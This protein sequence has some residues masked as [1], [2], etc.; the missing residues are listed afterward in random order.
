MSNLTRTQRLEM[1]PDQFMELKSK[2]TGL[3]TSLDALTLSNSR[4]E[5]GLKIINLSLDK[6][7]AIID[8]RQENNSKRISSL[9][10]WRNW[11]TGIG[12]AIVGFI[13]FFKDWIIEII[14]KIH[15]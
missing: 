5:D 10:K 3:D 12:V 11:T 1:L 4:V 6:L 7:T 14:K 15:P 13:G 8:R 9:E 2:V